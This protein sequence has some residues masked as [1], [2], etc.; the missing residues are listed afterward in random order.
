M[1][2]LEQVYKVDYLIF[3]VIVR[4]TFLVELQSVVKY[5]LHYLWLMPVKQWSHWSTIECLKRSSWRFRSI[6]LS[7]FQSRHLTL[8]HLSKTSDVTRCEVREAIF[9]ENGTISVSSEIIFQILLSQFTH[10]V[11]V[12]ILLNFI[13][14]ISLAFTLTLKSS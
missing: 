3:F 11:V 1:F 12:F 5:I 14:G 6:Q 10:M 8:S 9:I 2:L 13:N 4:V 7:S